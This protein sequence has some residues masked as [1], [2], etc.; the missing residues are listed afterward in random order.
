MKNVLVKWFI[1]SVWPV[2][3]QLLVK[4]GAE[5][6]EFVFQKV[7]AFMKE[8]MTGVFNR[9]QEQAEENMKNAQS[10]SD[11]QEKKKYQ[12]EAESYKRQAEAYAEMCR[13]WESKFEEFKRSM[14]KEVKEKTENLK[15]DDLFN[16]KAK[17]SND[18]LIQ[19]KESSSILLLE[20][21]KEI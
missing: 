14:E 7:T 4:Y 8:W 10:A 21:K 13:E 18:N 6:L 15:P 9:K 3:K 1:K 16:V 17:K 5:I 11:E 12:D 19:L 20:N 2:I